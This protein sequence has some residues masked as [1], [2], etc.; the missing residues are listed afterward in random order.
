MYVNG[1]CSAIGCSQLGIESTGTN[2]DETKVTGKRIVN[3]YAFDEFPRLALLLDDREAIVLLDH[4]L[5]CGQVL[6]A[7]NDEEPGRVG[8]DCLVLGRVELDARETALLPALAQVGRFLHPAAG[9]FVDAFVPGSE[10]RLV[11]RQPR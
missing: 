10:D 7:G 11:L 4:N 8:T 9:R 2:A 3:P 6:V 5:S 1:L